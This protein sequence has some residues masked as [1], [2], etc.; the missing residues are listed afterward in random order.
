MANKYRVFTSAEVLEALS[1]KGQFL[2]AA[3]RKGCRDQ[4][5]QL[6]YWDRNNPG[7]R[8]RILE[9]SVYEASADGTKVL[10]ETDHGFKGWVPVGALVYYIDYL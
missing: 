6:P 1:K 8:E 5:P 10:L 2:I 9:G 3:C 4:M 7:E